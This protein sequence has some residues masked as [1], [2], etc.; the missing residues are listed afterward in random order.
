MNL[1][2]IKFRLF[3][4]DR[5]QLVDQEAMAYREGLGR[6]VVLAGVCLRRDVAGE[7]SVVGLLPGAAHGI[8]I[9]GGDIV[10][11]LAVVPKCGGEVNMC[12]VRHSRVEDWPQAVT[13]AAKEPNASFRML[14]LRRSGGKETMSQVDLAQVDLEKLKQDCSESACRAQACAAVCA[15]AEQGDEAFLRLLLQATCCA[16]LPAD[17]MTDGGEPP[18]LIAAR[19]GSGNCVRCLLHFGASTRTTT[20]DGK[21]A[22][23]CAALEGHLEC[24]HTLHAAGADV[25]ARDMHGFR[26]LHGAALRGHSECLE[27]LL[28][29]GADVNAVIDDGKTPAY[30]A[31]MKGHVKCL[32]LLKR[33]HADF[34]LGDLIMGFRPVQAAVLNGHLAAVMYLSGGDSD[35]DGPVDSAG[36]LSCSHGCD[37]AGESGPS[38]YPSASRTAFAL[39]SSPGRGICEDGLLYC[40]SAAR[41]G[42]VSVAV[43]HGVEERVGRRIVRRNFDDMDRQSACLFAA[44]I[45]KLDGVGGGNEAGQEAG[46][47]GR[48]SAGD[49][50]F[51]T[52][53][54]QSVPQRML[55]N[56]G[57]SY[58]A[59]CYFA[60]TM[61]TKAS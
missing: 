61:L 43:G 14:V 23:F 26:A 20:N 13:T 54:L 56:I 35:D 21:A 12:S 42:H 9:V 48:G 19:N 49:G 27:A 24:V 8:D 36:S 15:A 45:G 33:W 31:A 40:Q 30:L 51:G 11:R 6:I 4:S 10:C 46:G 60:A 18:L 5:E 17:A 52:H 53:G 1:Y 41:P 44:M 7:V 39:S 55:K 29:M 38:S 34:S 58:L 37:A 28:R 22:L 2:H 3:H 32:R 59:T 25:D 50:G 16:D 47:T 57:V